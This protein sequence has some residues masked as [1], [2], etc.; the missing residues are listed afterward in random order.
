MT[1]LLG[2]YAALV[3]RPYVARLNAAAVLVGL[4]YG[5]RPLALVLFAR[6]ATGSYRDAAIVAAAVAIGTAFLA[7][8][9]GRAVDRRGAAGVIS[10]TAVAQAIA[11]GGLIAAGLAHAPLVVLIVLGLLSGAAQPPVGTTLRTLTLEGLVGDDVDVAMSMQA[12]LNEIFF[13]TG[14]LLAA[15][16]IAIGSPQLAL[17][18]MA[19]AVLVGSLVFAAAQPVRDH[20]GEHLPGGR[21]AVFA[22]PG[23]RTL[24]LTWWTS[25]VCFGALDVSLPAFAD[26]HG[27]AAVGGVMLAAISIGVMVGSIAFGSRKS[28]R[29]PGSRYIAAWALAALFVA[30]LPLA[31]ANWQLIPLC[32]VFGLSIAPATVLGFIMVGEV[33][34]KG[35][36]TEGASWL[37]AS[38]G[39]GSAVGAAV[40]GVVIDSASARAALLV[41]VAAQVFGVLVLLVRRRTLAPAEAVA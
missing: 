16:L 30:P 21:L 11:L 38:V 40:V 27:A 17:G 14:P 15:L 37:G 28:S 2:P 20:R 18:V 35:A 33:T 10:S 31:T 22:H 3:R 4:P 7:P 23:M 12:F 13:F 34:T 5:M 1:K 25:G 19:G 36:R 26:A 41:S 9:R 6:A 8:F 32:L 24:M 39:V 29:D